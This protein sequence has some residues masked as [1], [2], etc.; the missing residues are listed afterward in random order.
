MGRLTTKV[1]CIVIAS[2]LSAGGTSQ[3]REGARLTPDEYWA[4]VEKIVEA[5]DADLTRIGLKVQQAIKGLEKVSEGERKRVLQHVAGLYE[6]GERSAERCA[7]DLKLLQPPRG[8]EAFHATLVEG[9]EKGIG[10][11]RRMT[12]GVR[13]EDCDGLQALDVEAKAARRAA[14][15]AGEQAMAALSEESSLADASAASEEVVGKVL[16]GMA[17]CAV[18]VGGPLAWWVWGRGKTCPACGAKMGRGLRCC[19][20][21]GCDVAEANRMH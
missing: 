2:M 9:A 20:R 7:T 13:R 11:A 21:C 18:L 1:A 8:Y 19:P 10:L 16:A 15:E 6:E 12:E 17:G 5:K 14:E 4:S 3:E